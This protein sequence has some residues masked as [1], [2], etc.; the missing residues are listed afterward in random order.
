M[1]CVPGVC[2]CVRV[3]VR[4]RVFCL[5]GSATQALVTV[6][7]RKESKVYFLH[8]S[9]ASRPAAGCCAIAMV[10]IMVDVW[11]SSL[12]LRTTDVY[13]SITSM[14]SSA[15]S[16]ESDHHFELF[17]LRSPAMHSDG[18]VYCQSKLTTGIPVVN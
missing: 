7:S 12:L 13:R 11:P 8:D 2:V 9:A 14:I 5:W 16:R 3:C 6:K 17:T 1:V 15:Y 18:L 4:V 10:P